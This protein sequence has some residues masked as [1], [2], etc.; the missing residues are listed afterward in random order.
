[1]FR[2]RQLPPDLVPAREA[3]DRVIACLEPAKERL[4]EVLPGTRRPGRPLPEAL[5]SYRRAL[6]EAGDLMSGWRVT[7]VE[8]EWTACRAA[9]DEA[10]RLAGV[11]DAAPAPEGFESLLGTVSALID[12]LEPF[13]DAE[14]SFRRLRR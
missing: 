5:D 11:I 10:E 1:M 4:A 3:F 6:T 12:A 7:P 2:R 9:L 13:A 14:E 8:S